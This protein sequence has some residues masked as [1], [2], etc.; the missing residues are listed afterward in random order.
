MLLI[1]E[2]FK[3]KPIS[4][5]LIQQPIDMKFYFALVPL[6]SLNHVSTAFETRKFMKIQQKKGENFVYSKVHHEH[7][8]SLF[9]EKM[10]KSLSADDH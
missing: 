9:F 1:F 2:L 4:Q 6:S 5:L 10:R 7:K 8:S 3:N